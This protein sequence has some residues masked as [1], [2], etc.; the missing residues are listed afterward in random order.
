M[1]IFRLIFN[2]IEV[3]TYILADSSGKCAVI[4]CGCYNRKE[5]SRLTQ[6]LEKKELRP[7][8]LLNTHCH[9]DHI[10]GNRMFL[11]KYKI[12]ALADRLED[13]NRLDSPDHARLFGLSVEMP[14]EPSGYL[15]DGDT[16][17]FGAE[18][19]SVLAVP[20]HS[21]GGLAFY[22][23]KDGVVFTGDALFSGSIGRTDLAGG[24]YETLIH[25][26]KNK[27]FILPPSTIVYPGHGEETTIGK[28]LKTNPYFSDTNS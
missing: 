15:N 16:V 17:T 5:F 11:E 26:I 12:G 10:F 28:E 27:L 18:S 9:L 6:F 8:L 7:E 1:E 14:P 4:D 3:N 22:S 21:R 23:S 13:E 25:S 20:G 24:S 19:M 2:P